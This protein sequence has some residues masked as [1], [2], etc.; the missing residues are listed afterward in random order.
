MEDSDVCGGTGWSWNEE[1]NCTHAHENPGIALI[2]SQGGQAVCQC[3]IGT[4]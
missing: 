4:P 3:N 1:K 2:D